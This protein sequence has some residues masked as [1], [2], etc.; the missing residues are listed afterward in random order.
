MNN[1]Q[2]VVRNGLE[3]DSNDLIY[4]GNNEGNAI[5]VIDPSNETALTFL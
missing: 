5:N 2:K 1:G 3:T 4:A